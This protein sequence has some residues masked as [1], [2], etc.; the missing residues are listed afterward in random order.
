MTERWPVQHRCGH[1]VEW[2]LSRKHPD[3]RIGYAHWLAG[4]DCTR[5]WWANRRDPHQQARAARSRLRQVLQVQAWERQHQMPP[6]AGRP[7]AVAWAR[8]VRHRLVTRGAQTAAGDGQQHC[9]DI[10]A[11]AR[12]ITT[13]RWWIDHRHLDPATVAAALK[14]SSRPQPPAPRPRAGRPR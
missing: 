6:L 5:C 13:A 10:R 14:H 12:R 4:R 9:D 2:D 7:K 3:D 1:R 8:K 11:A